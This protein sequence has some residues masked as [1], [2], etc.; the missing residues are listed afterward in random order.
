MKRRQFLANSAATVTA[1]ATATALSC[2]AIAALE[3]GALRFVPQGG[4]NH[5]D[6]LVTLAPNARNSGHMIWDSLY[7]QTVTGEV[8]P[9][10]VAGHEISSDGRTWRFTLRDEGRTVAIGKVEKLRPMATA[11]AVAGGSAGAK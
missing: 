7:G 5:P 8:L 6:P 3:P 1:M 11:V 2:P 4:L 10:M 9:Q